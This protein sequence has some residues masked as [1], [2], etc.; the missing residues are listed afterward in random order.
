MA[1]DTVG[2]TMTTDTRYRNRCLLLAGSLLFL[3]MPLRAADEVVEPCDAIRARVGVAPLADPDFLRL[4]ATRQDCTF[5]AAEFYRAAY[6]DRP[7]PPPE[8][9][10]RSRHGHD[11]DD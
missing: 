2:N 8:R 1:G 3:S 11:D 10:E 5:T 6:G 9:H 7:L 4:L